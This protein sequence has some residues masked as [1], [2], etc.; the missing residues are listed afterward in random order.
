VGF[1]AN[2]Y[3]R[4]FS[5]NAFVIMVRLPPSLFPPHLQATKLLRVQITGILFQVPSGLGKGGLQC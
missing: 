5:G 2:V 3:G 1:V 4:F